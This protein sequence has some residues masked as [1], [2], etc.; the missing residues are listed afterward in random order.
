[1]MLLACA[2]LGGILNRFSGFENVAWLPGRNVYYALLAV[3]GVSWMVF[4]PFWALLITLSAG[5]YRIPGWYKS[6][7]MGVN[8]GSLAVDAAIMFG[9]GLF[10]APLFL[11]AF[12]VRGAAPALI[13]LALASGAATLAY[14][15]GNYFLRNKVRDPFVYI[16]ALAGAAF[17]AAV[18][19]VM[20]A[21]NG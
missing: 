1:M 5:L 21:V 11:Y 2:V 15:V 13:Y 16:E 8:E 17:G 12:F 6:I 4:G 18:G 19:G 14:I 9:R 20:L 7:D 10:F 3:L